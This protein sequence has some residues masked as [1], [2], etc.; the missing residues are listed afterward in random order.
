VRRNPAKGRVFRAPPF[1]GAPVV[2]PRAG[3]PIGAHPRPEELPIRQI[4]LHAKPRAIGV[5]AIAKE[6]CTRSTTARLLLPS[7]SGATLRLVASPGPPALALTI[8]LAKKVAGSLQHYY[9]CGRGQTL[10]AVSPGYK[11]RRRGPQGQGR[12]DMHRTRRERPQAQSRKDMHRIAIPKPRGH[13]SHGRPRM[14]A[15]P[16]CERR[17]DRRPRCRKERFEKRLQELAEMFAVAVG[18]FSLMNNREI[19]RKAAK[20]QKKRRTNGRFQAIDPD[21]L[22]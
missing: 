7:A 9:R 8:S 18:G 12:K 1:A 15:C 2:E 13:A 20:P 11:F 16:F 17:P 22:K 6:H 21:E 10:V 19:S 3:F 4:T 5:S 14:S